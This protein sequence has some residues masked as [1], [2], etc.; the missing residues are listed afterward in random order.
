ME[1]LKAHLNSLKCDLNQIF[2][3]MHLNL[4]TQIRFEIV[5]HSLTLK[6]ILDLT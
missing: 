6:A 4:C 3:S 2:I 1:H 5:T